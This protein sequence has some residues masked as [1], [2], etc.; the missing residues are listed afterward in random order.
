MIYKDKPAIISGGKDNIIK[1]WHLEN[2]QRIKSFLGHSGAI[3][4]LAVA[5]NG[6]ETLIFSLSD[7]RSLKMWSA[8]DGTCIISH[9][10]SEN[11]FLVMKAIT[12]NNK[13]LLISV[14]CERTEIKISNPYFKVPIRVIKTRVDHLTTTFYK[15]KPV[16]VITCQNDIKIFDLYTGEEIK[17][18]EKRNHKGV[19]SLSAINN[20]GEIY[21]VSTSSDSI[22][23]WDKNLM[24]LG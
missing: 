8:I 1:M 17:S 14:N 22:I 15:G 12:F 13:A 6:K 5:N 19:L 7:D 24:M 2:G 4:S 18:N 23:V 20:K 11:D 16:V 10:N 3:T 9:N 21:I